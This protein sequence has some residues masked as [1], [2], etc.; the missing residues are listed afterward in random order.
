MN[1]LG[2][3][4]FTAFGA[5]HDRIE[6][7]TAF[8]MLMQQRPSAF[9]DHVRVTPMHDCHHDRIEI[10]SLMGE[11]V[12]V[13]FRRFLIGDAAQHA[14]PD[15]FLQPFG[16]QMAC[17]SE[18]GLKSLETARAQEAFAQDQKG[19]AVANH[20]DGPSHRTRLFLQL[21]PS[22]SCSPVIR[23]PFRSNRPGNL[24][25]RYHSS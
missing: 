6:V 25:F 24:W 14:L 1:L 21:I 19:L 23:R 10:E 22:H 17:D 13:P 11:D 18:R 3:K 9:V 16:E 4:R 5:H 20:A 7:L 2:R 8:A 12:F 15:Q